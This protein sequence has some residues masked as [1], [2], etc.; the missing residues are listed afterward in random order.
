MDGILFDHLASWEIDLLSLEEN[1]L[2][3]VEVVRV[4]AGIGILG[5]F[6]LFIRIIFSHFLLLALFRFKKI[7]LALS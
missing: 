6:T 1:V 5:W 2:V 3:S 7:T 4:R